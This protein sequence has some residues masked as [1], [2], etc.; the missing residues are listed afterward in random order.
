MKRMVQNTG[1]F[2]AGF[3]LAG[4]VMADTS[5]TWVLESQDGTV[6]DFDVTLRF[7]NAERITGQAPCNT[8]SASFDGSMEQFTIGPILA[9]RRACPALTQETAYFEALSGMTSAALTDSTLELT[10]PSATALLFTPAD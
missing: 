1:L 3:L 5:T 9:T 2:C 6:V 7:E 8:Y 4:T 10:G